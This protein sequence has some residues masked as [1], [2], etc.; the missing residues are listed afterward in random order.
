MLLIAAFFASYLLQTNKIT[1]IHETVVSIFAGTS[2]CPPS[3][4]YCIPVLLL[5]KTYS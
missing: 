4:Q 1:A 2:C 3:S 5:T